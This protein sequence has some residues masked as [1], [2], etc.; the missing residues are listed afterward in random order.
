MIKL[1]IK[2]ENEGCLFEVINKGDT[3]PK[4]NWDH[5]FD[6]FFN[7]KNNKKELKIGLGLSFCKK[8]VTAHGGWIKVESEPEKG[9]KFQFF[10]PK[11]KSNII[12]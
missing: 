2:I 6:K 7:V 4:K 1:I 3:I 10:L 12:E 5:I 8:A 9:T 11:E